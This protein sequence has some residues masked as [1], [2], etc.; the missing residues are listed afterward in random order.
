MF[1]HYLLRRLLIASLFILTTAGVIMAHPLGNFTVNHFVRLETG[2]SR[3]RLHYVVDMAEIPT[4]QATQEMGLGDAGGTPSKDAL[5]AYLARVAAQYAAG[6]L[7]DVDGARVPLRAV[8]QSINMPQGSGGLRTLRVE[9]DFEGDVPAQE[10]SGAHR[11]RFEDTNQRERIGWHEIV[12]V[13]AAGL[14]IFNSNAYGSAVTDE[15]KTYPQDM[16]TVPLDERTAG[17]SWT[18][19]SIPAGAT[20]LR[21]RDGRVAEQSRDRFAELIS[22]Q[23]VTPLV[24]FL[25]LLLAAGLGALHAFSPG[26]GKTVVGA[27]LVGTRGTARHAAF[28]GLTVTITHTIGVFALGVVTLFASQYIL[29]EKLF[30]VLSFVSGAIVLAIGLSLF[31]K[32]LRSSLGDTAQEQEHHHHEHVHE[33]HAHDG[34]THQHHVD[35]SLVHS[36]GGRAHSHLPPGADGGRVTWRNLLALGISGGLLPCPSALVVL[37]SAISLHRVGY[38]MALVLAFSVGLAATLTGIGLAFVYAGRLIKGPIRES[39]IVRVLPALSALVIACVGAAICYEALAQSGVHLSALTGHLYGQGNA[40]AGGGVGGAEGPS[41]A[42]LGAF[43]VL[44]LGLVFGLKHATEVDHVVAVSTIV[45]EHR[46]VWRSAL[47]GGLWGMGHTASLIIVGVIVLALRVAI[48]EHVSNWLEFGVALM[49][50][51]LGINAFVRALRGRSDVHVH[52]HTHE[53]AS[54]A[55]I[56]FHEDGT[57]H[58][59]PSVAHSHVVSRIGF[60]P[61]LVGAMHGLAGSGALTVLVLAQIDSAILGLLYLTV[62]GIGSIL[63]MLLMSFLVGLP[64]A[65][66][67]RRLSGF[68]Y[69]L[70]TIA[71]ALSI[72]FGFWYAYET[73]IASG[74]LKT[75]I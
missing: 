61:L 12:V 20:A 33:G 23:E 4:F 58:A 72:C 21:M 56:H 30:P 53:G 66:S 63:G 75:I 46:S 51:G 7:I 50:I 59:E 22:V 16:L 57:E 9:C 71:G 5:D 31:I 11:L 42:S 35:T 8:S 26:H 14:S 17:L 47:V 10:A 54:H 2:A 38:G 69:G 68:N 19:G 44:G 1:N 64:F 41:L 67:A 65:L 60:K 43:A 15:L 73:G 32:R 27:Y 29:P 18:N 48:P 40:Q 62:F 39:R 34:H 36:H 3:I 74:L 28:L 25:G 52:Q 37:L 13:P 55:H 49:I 45:S 70:Q 24:A 6:L